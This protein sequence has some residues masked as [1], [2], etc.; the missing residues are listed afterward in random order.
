M[1]NRGAFQKILQV[2]KTKLFQS[3]FSDLAEALKACP[4]TALLSSLLHSSLTIY[5]PGRGVLF[6]SFLC[7]SLFVGQRE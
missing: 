3:F 1:R 5:L 6:G 7:S 2:N 4:H